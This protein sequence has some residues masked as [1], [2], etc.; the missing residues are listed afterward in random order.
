M[1]CAKTKLATCLFVTI[2][3]VAGIANASVGTQI[4]MKG[5]SQTVPL[6][7]EIG[8]VAVADPDICDYL[9]GQGRRSI[10]LNARGGGET[11]VTLWDAGGEKRD[12]FAVRVVTTTL[13]EAI[14]KAKGALGDISGID[15]RI[16]GGR[17]EISGSVA[18]PDDYRMIEA[19]SRSDNRIRS[20]VRLTND[21]MS[22]IAD[23]V[24][25]A[26]DVPGVKVRALRDKIVL[27]GVVYSGS[28]KEKAV[29]IA[30]LYTQDV[31]DLI[32]VRES[33]RSAG[34][35]SLI[36]LEF[37]L[38]EIKKSALRQLAFNWAPGSL[39]NGGGGTAS[40]GGGLFSSASQLGKTIL[41]FVMNFIP[42]L[43]FI[44]ERGDGRVLE[45]PKIVVKSGEEARIFSG[46]EVPY[47]KGE[48]VQF[49][50]V[51]IDIVASPIEVASGVDIKLTATL[52][53]PSADIRGAVDTHTVSTTAICP[54]GQS[55]IL[56]NIIRNGDVKMK[57]RV[58]RGMDASTAIFT[59]FLSKDFQS[60]RSEFVIFVTPKLIKQPSPAD[61][62]FRS[63]LANEEAMIRDRS[64]KEFA[65]YMKS[66]GIE[67]EDK[68]K[69]RRRRGKWR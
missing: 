48:E 19:L 59:L 8:D 2:L 28:D 43:R 1:T 10:Y 57:H 31:L 60:N 55:V 21:V 16:V 58:P 37:H 65:Q 27:D 26:L 5:Q 13:K 52:S 44:R 20:R 35:G 54:F 41:G 33:G 46:S 40:A 12:E 11:T 15:V 42:K 62:E 17:V 34:R 22:R 6:E 32:E 7:Y 3:L 67:V 50:K 9:V 66:K 4:L 30:R 51:G 36:E 38:M 68:K 47:L 14:G 53:A 18:H 39:G 56:G 45:N 29:Q 63:F 49:K 64:K 69:K 24:R 25:G 61:V 23:A